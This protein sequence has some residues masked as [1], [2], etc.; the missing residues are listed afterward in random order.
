M[1]GE[2]NKYIYIYII[3]IVSRGIFSLPQRDAVGAL[4]SSRAYKNGAF[5]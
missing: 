4:D 2:F 3:Q 5:K 1:I